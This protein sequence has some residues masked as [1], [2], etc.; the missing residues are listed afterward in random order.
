MSKTEF[1]ADVDYTVFWPFLNYNFEI[2]IE[3]SLF[4]ETT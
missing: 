4:I 1:N 2:S 3:I